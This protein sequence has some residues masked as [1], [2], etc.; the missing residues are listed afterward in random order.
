M[1]R[2][3]CLNNTA[4]TS[5]LAWFREL[6]L[7]GEHSF[8][9]AYQPAKGGPYFEIDR[10]VDAYEKY[11]FSG[12]DIEETQNV[13][14]ELAENLQAALRAEDETGAL[15]AS[16]RILGWGGVTNT[17]T[18]AW[19]LD[20]HERSNLVEMLNSA[21]NS[22]TGE[23][24]FIIEQFNQ[25]QPFRSDSAT[26]KIF[27]MKDTGS[28]IYDDRVASAIGWLVVNHSGSEG[29]TSVPESLRFCV[30]T[31]AN[32]NPSQGRLKLPVRNSGRGTD[33][34][35]SNLRF[36]WILEWLSNDDQIAASFGLR[37]GPPVVRAIEA[38][39]FMIGKSIGTI[40]VP[41]PY[42]DSV[43]A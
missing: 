4:V 37:V 29:W 6:I 36:N 13:T 9:Q 20:A 24:D 28:A 31:G 34:A 19:L 16:L 14:D 30:K 35:L 5:F 10:F 25:Q 18:V 39:L 22:L 42:P 43:A 33:H 38:A 15:T 1:T 40:A 32:Y 2:N 23:N 11:Y 12:M 27:A 21:A 26:T 41:R 3:E 17:A 8:V 7:A